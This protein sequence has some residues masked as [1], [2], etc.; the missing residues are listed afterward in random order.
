MNMWFPQPS[1]GE[2]IAFLCVLA[3]L[4]WCAVELVLWLLSFIEI[5]I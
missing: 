3:L 5:T 4:G 2:V 1:K